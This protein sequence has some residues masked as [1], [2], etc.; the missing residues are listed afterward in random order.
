MID[1]DLKILEQRAKLLA[2]RKTGSNEQLDFP[3]FLRFNI[4][5]EHFALSLLSVREVISLK[6]ITPLPGTPAFI[7]GIVNYRGEILSI[8]NFKILMQLTERGLTEMNKIMV[9]ENE[10]MRFGVLVDGVSE[11]FHYNDQQLSAKPIN[12]NGFA[13]DVTLGITQHGVVIIDA[14]RFMNHQSVILS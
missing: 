6:D 8:V 1:K 5:K 10:T 11:V 14:N 9:M 4:G 7:A 3:K 13:N 2:L 12:F